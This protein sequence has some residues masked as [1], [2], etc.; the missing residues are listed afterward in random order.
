MSL[1]RWRQLSGQLLSGICELV[2]HGQ[3]SCHLPGGE[4]APAGPYHGVTSA[5]DGGESGVILGGW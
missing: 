1:S 4:G 2:K 3:L 5:C